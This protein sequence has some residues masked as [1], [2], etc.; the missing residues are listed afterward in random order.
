MPTFILGINSAYHESAACLLRDGMILAAAEEERF[1]RRKHGKPARVDNPD[2]LPEAAIDY[3]LGVAGIS[4]G[5]VDHVGYSFEPELR[6]RK[7]LFQEPVVEGSWGS[8]AGEEEFYHRLLRVPGVLAA[9]GFQGTFHWI[10]HHRCHAASAFYASPFDEAAIL[11]IDGIGELATTCL[12]HGHGNSIDDLMDLEYPH[13][14]GF[15]WEKLSKFLGFSEYDACKVMGLGAFGSP[16]T[17]ARQFEALYSLQPGGSF[18]LRNDVLRFRAEDYSALSELFGL[19]RR[20]PGEELGQRHADLAAALQA[21]T[22]R[23]VV[24]LAQEVYRRTA[25]QNLCLAGG[26][27]LNC[28]TNL[29]LLLGTSFDAFSCNPRPTMPERR[30]VRH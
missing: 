3:C 8:E 27:A 14:V 21:C 12:G 20:V 23:I 17:F 25:V 11:A 9:A 6:R 26:V 10:K 2:C 5:D 22:D 16:A 30:S 1:N 18:A 29:R 28:V 15:L 4:M 7:S 13:S 24:H 19:R